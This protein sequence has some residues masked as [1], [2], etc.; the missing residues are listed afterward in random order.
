MSLTY[1]EAFT[2]L[3]APAYHVWGN[4]LREELRPE[5]QEL[6]VEAGLDSASAIQI[7][8]GCYNVWND[9]QEDVGP[10]PYANV[11]EV[12]RNSDI[13]PV[14]RHKIQGVAPQNFSASTVLPGVEPKKI[15]MLALVNHVEGGA[16]AIGNR[17]FQRRGLVFVQVGIPDDRDKDERYLL[18]RLYGIT[19]PLTELYQSVVET[20][21]IWINNVISREQTVGGGTFHT[22][23]ARFLYDQT[24]DEPQITSL[25]ELMEPAMATMFTEEEIRNIARIIA[26]GELQTFRDMLREFAFKTGPKVPADDVDAAIARQTAVDAV[27]T[28]ADAALPKAGGTLT[29]PL[30]LAG[31]PTEDAQAANKKYVDE[32]TG[33]LTAAQAEAIAA[34]EAAARYTNTEKARVATIPDK[35]DKSLYD[36]D[37]AAQDTRIQALV[38]GGLD[39]N[40]LTSAKILARTAVEKAGWRGKII[41]SHV[42]AGTSLPPFDEHND[43][44]VFILAADVANGLNFVDISNRSLVLNAASAGDVMLLLPTRDSKQWVRVGTILG[45]STRV[46]AALDKK[47]NEADVPGVVSAALPPF[48]D[49]TPLPAGIPGSDFPEHIDVVFSEKQTN[50]AIRSIALNIAGNPGTLDNSTPISAID[51]ANELRGVLRF[52]FTAEQRTNLSTSAKRENTLLLTAQVIITFTDDTTFAHD[53][54]FLVNNDIFAI[55]MRFEQVV[56]A[57]PATLPEGSYELSAKIIRTGGNAAQAVKR[58]LLS[59]IG[60]TD[61]DFKAQLGQN[62][63]QQGSLRARYAPDS[64]T[65]TYSWQGDRTGTSQLRVIGVS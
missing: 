36:R 61:Q 5:A 31:A 17:L 43:G 32:N 10:V 41:A 3:V 28:T 39:D 23:Q 14:I 8:G 7:A 11:R 42:S 51:A 9:V 65:L 60:T 57:S 37:Q 19:Q 22:V 40:V 38:Q 56:G 12:L 34:Q 59:E 2:R 55:P 18:D 4:V 45:I 53:F 13:H 54:P 46:Q 58:I 52:N 26:E 27:K 25:I 49:I 47:A 24:F 1:S 44:D 29:G 20:D 15:S 48:F 64:R 35:I 50:K 63:A 21:G 30:T 6:N 62:N 33:G 16:G